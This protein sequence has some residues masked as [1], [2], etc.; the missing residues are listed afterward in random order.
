[1][2][3]I[4]EDVVRLRRWN[5]EFD[6]LLVNTTTPIHLRIPLDKLE[7]F[8]ISKEEIIQNGAKGQ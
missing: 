7:K 4:D 1:M 2:P 6:Q 8:I 3:S 5:P